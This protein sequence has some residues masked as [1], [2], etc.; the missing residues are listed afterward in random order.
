MLFHYIDFPAHDQL[1]AIVNAHIPGVVRRAPR[2][3]SEKVRGP[4]K[5]DGRGQGRGRKASFDERADRLVQGVR[6]HP[7]DE[8]LARLE[9]K[10]PYPSVLLKAFE[11][12]I[13]YL[14]EVSDDA[15]A[16]R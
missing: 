7:D 4:T 9:G 3:S 8:V 1:I 11:D 13:R 10:L 16:N 14:D 6:R 2:G 15:D 5:S 12:H